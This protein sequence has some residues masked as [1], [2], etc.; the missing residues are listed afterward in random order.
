MCYIGTYIEI[1]R[2]V[3]IDACEV[4]L[5]ADVLAE[6]VKKKTSKGTCEMLRRNRMRYLR[7]QCGYCGGRYGKIR[8]KRSETGGKRDLFPIF[9]IAAYYELLESWERGLL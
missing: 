1:A 6:E 9:P 5:D 3:I 7:Q 8:G 4:L 2:K